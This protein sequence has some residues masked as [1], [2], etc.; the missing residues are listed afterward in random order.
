MKRKTWII[1][2]VVVLVL[3]LIGINVWK[4]TGAA[5]VV[6]ETTTLMKRQVAETVIVPGILTVKDEQLVYE[7]QDKGTIAEIFVKEGDDVKK[8]DPLL[9]YENEQL[10]LDIEQNELQRRSL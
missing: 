3:L 7:E 10:K 8:G 2:G 4:K 5:P 1:T 9:R 6:V